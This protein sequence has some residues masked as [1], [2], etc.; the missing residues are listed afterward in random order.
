M[1]GTSAEGNVHAKTGTLDKV[2]ALSGYVTTTDGRIL[3][4]SFVANNFT[5]RSRD[6]DRAV[7]GILARLAGGPLPR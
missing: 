5:L 7:D 3:V 2:R 6:V 4:F 1:K